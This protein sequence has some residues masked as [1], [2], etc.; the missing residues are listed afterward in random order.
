MIEFNKKILTRKNLE[1]IFS[2]KIPN[3]FQEKFEKEIKIF[4]KNIDMYNIVDKLCPNM[5]CENTDFELE[6][7]NK[8]REQLKKIYDNFHKIC[9]DYDYFIKKF[10]SDYNKLFLSFENEFKKSCENN[11]KQNKNNFCYDISCGIFSPNEAH[12]RLFFNRIIN[13]K[14]SNKCN[15]VYQKLKYLVDN[16]YSYLYI[17]TEQI[18]YFYFKLF[19][20]KNKDKKLFLFDKYL[21]FIKNNPFIVNNFDKEEITELNSIWIFYKHQENNGTEITYLD[22]NKIEKH[23]LIVDKIYSTLRPI[24][25]FYDLIDKINDYYREIESITNPAG[26]TGFE[27][28]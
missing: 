13:N 1:L 22:F 8:M 24:Y 27:S 25:H 19:K 6:V 15:K 5:W 10:K 23:I 21:F 4:N 17:K 2:K 16:F 28:D 14:L 18:L 20:T 11:E 3:I 9:N 12:Q 26:L 7:L